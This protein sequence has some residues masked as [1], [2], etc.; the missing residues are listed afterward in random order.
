MYCKIVI[1]NYLSLCWDYTS[2][3]IENINIANPCQNCTISVSDPFRD[4]IRCGNAFVFKLLF[5]KPL[6]MKVI[7]LTPLEDK[8]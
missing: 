8:C 7:I 6:E 5:I 1:S 2:R 4:D 3:K